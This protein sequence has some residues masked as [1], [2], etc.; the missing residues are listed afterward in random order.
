MV[1]TVHAHYHIET[2]ITLRIC[3]FHSATYYFAMVL[4]RP[5]G[6]TRILHNNKAVEAAPLD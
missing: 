4:L 6:P 3:R 1:C 2:Q 5:K